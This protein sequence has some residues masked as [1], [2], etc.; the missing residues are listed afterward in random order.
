MVASIGPAKGSARPLPLSRPARNPS[1]CY[2]SLWK[3][4]ASAQAFARLYAQELGRKYSGFKLAGSAENTP[5]ANIPEGTVEKVYST[6][7]GPVVIT[8]RGK[9]VFVTESFD[10]P[11]A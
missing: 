1:H 8:E 9:L 11:M 5:P 10:L 6:N 4:P 3:S 7:E 2:L